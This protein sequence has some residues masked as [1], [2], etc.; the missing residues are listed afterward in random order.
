MKRTGFVG[1]TF[2]R[3]TVIERFK[4]P[5]LNVFFFRA[6]CQCGTVKAIRASSV[7]QGITKSCGCLRRERLRTHGKSGSAAHR[8]WCSIKNR[9]YNPH[10]SNFQHYGGRGITMHPAWRDSFK[11]FRR[12][13]GDPPRGKRIDRKENNGNYEPGN[14]R[15]VDAVTQ[16]NNK[17]N[18]HVV[19][20]KG[21]SKTLAEWE[22]ATGIQA[23]TIRARLRVGWSVARALK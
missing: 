11:A 2:G 13:V 7:T 3:L 5:T 8:L 15:F 12:D 20:F 1:R 19:T 16:Q 4:H 10:A 18:N 22:R 14:I 6:R 9:C 21:Q 23:S 17:R